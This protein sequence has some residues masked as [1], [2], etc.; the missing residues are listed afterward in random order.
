MAM[1]FL[2]SHMGFQLKNLHYTNFRVFLKGIDNVIVIQ[3]S[4]TAENYN[5]N[6]IENLEFEIAIVS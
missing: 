3:E 2:R 5:S 1:L 6:F 4:T